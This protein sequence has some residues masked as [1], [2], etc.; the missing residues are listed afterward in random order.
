MELLPGSIRVKLELEDGTCPGTD[1]TLLAH[2]LERLSVNARETARQR[3]KRR[4]GTD[5]LR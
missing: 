4:E 2:E 5:A 3:D 1:P